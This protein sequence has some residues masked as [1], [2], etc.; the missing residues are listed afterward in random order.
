MYTINNIFFDLDDETRAKYLDASVP[1]EW[2]KYDE[3]GRNQSAQERHQK[4]IPWVLVDRRPKTA[5]NETQ[6]P[7]A[8]LVM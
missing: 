2:D 3:L 5:N 7:G 4:L 8:V 6:K 1:R